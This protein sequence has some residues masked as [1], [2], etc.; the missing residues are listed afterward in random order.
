MLSILCRYFRENFIASQEWQGPWGIIEGHCLFALGVMIQRWTWVKPQSK[1]FACVAFLV[2]GEC[3]A[4][5]FSN[6]YDR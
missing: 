5:A 2:L 4:S 3:N 1:Q 6:P